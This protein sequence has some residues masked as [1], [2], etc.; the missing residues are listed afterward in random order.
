MT[1]I[2]TVPIEANESAQ[3]FCRVLDAH[4]WVAI[5]APVDEASLGGEAGRDELARSLA[6]ISA[7]VPLRRSR[8]RGSA[9]SLN[10]LTKRGEPRSWWTGTY[11]DP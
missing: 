3:V 2:A 11:R 1:D 6:V 4:K 8:A 10:R 9:S 7:R 5:S